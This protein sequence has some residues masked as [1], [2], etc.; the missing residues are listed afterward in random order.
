MRRLRIGVSR[1]RDELEALAGEPVAELGPSPVEARIVIGTEAV[2]HQIDAAGVVAFLDLDQELLAPR[3]R[4][5]EQAFALLVRSARLLG[6]RA[7][8][9]RLVLQTRIPRHPAVLAALHADPAALS[10][11]ERTIREELGLPPFSALAAVSGP[12]ADN[13]VE[14]LTLPLGVEVLGPD[15]GRWLLRAPDHRALCDALAAAPRPPGRL[16]I[17]VDPL[18]T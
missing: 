17:E 12:A 9:G 5:G 11:G 2:L 4:A 3:Y 18:R 13:F 7:A 15:N 10:A 8:G 16:R 1:A 6:G 14:G